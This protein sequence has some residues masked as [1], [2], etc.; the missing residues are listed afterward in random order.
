MAKDWLNDLYSDNTKQAPK[1][2][3]PNIIQNILGGARSLGLGA[4]QDILAPTYLA[5]Q[6]IAHGQ[7]PT[8]IGGGQANAQQLNQYAQSNPF[9]TKDQL[10]QMG[11]AKQ[12]GQD[13][14][15]AASWAVPEAKAAEVANPLLRMLSGVATKGVQ[16]GIQGGLYAT[17]QGQN[18]IQGAVTG[19]VVNPA[20]AGAGNLLTDALPRYIGLRNYGADGKMLP[21]VVKAENAAAANGQTLKDARAQSLSTLPP[22]DINAPQGSPQNRFDLLD[23]IKNLASQPEWVGTPGLAEIKKGTKGSFPQQTGI[24]SDIQSAIQNSNDPFE[25]YSR[26]KNMAYSQENSSAGN[27]LSNFLKSAAAIT[28]EH[29]IN[30]SDN[31]SETRKAMDMYATQTAFKKSAQNPIQ[32]GVGELTGVGILGGLGAILPALSSITGP[33]AGIGALDTALTNKFTGPATARGLVNI[34]QSATNNG[35]EDILRK[36]GVIGAQGGV[37]SLQ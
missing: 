5:G 14:A 19:A 2:A 24:L 13:V 20:L 9:A 12:V 34:G 8:V 32:G 18:P 31:P 7:N 10:Q 17:S 33:V 27:R 37:N 26:L 22:F 36:L 6:E 25:A 30:A 23:K 28:R 21:E 1:T 15:G 35:V 4:I 16:G 3:Q 11:G 29:V